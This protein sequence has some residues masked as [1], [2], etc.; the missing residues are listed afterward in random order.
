MD[1]W[2]IGVFTSIDEGLGVKLDVVRELGIPTIQLHAP[3]A[4]QRTSDAALG[5]LSKLHEAGVR[6]TAVF[7]GFAGESYADIPTVERTVGLVPPATRNERLQ[8]LHEIADFAKLMGCGVV[9]LH[10]G[11]VGHDPNDDDYRALVEVTRRI[12]DHCRGQDQ[13][14]HLETGQESADD[15]LTFLSVVDR[16]NLFVNFDP[17]I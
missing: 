7:A 6:L 8:E 15:L 3:S 11:F 10:L 2:P 5:F 4:K 12:C 14:V 13:A 9:G 16:E 1:V 17:P